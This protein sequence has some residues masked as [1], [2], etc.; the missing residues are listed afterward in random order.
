MY[1]SLNY[2]SIYLHGLYGGHAKMSKNVL[3]YK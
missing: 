1:I 3:Y 2:H